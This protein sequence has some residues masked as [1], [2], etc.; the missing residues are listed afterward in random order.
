MLFKTPN[1]ITAIAVSAIFYLTGCSNSAHI[2]KD[3]SVNFKKY[4]T[5]AWIVPPESKGPKV[6]HANDIVEQNMRNEVAARLKKKGYVEATADPD[7]LVSADLMVQ[8]TTKRETETVYSQPYTQSYYNPYSRRLNSVY[9]P[10]QVRGYR[11]YNSKVK[12]GRVTV[13]LID[14]RTDKNVWQGWTGRTLKSA[15]SYYTSDDVESDVR[16]IF[17]KF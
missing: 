4:K 3:S 6:N 15:G 1:V 8:K 11:N 7:L 14:A 10:S 17:K 12:E 13:T 9:Y 2:E 16:T 5:Y